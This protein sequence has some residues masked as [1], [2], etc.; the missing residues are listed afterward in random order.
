MKDGTGKWNQDKQD[1]GWDRDRWDRGWKRERRDRG[2][3]PRQTGPEMG[4]ADGD[5]SNRTGQTGTVQTEPG[6]RGRFKQNRADGSGT[7]TVVTG[8]WAVTDGTEGRA[9]T[10]GTE[11]YGTG[12]EPGP[13]M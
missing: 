4:R 10:D 6:R 3:E 9:L 8:N 7:L 1:R 11:T 5:G 12:V 13:G 2:V